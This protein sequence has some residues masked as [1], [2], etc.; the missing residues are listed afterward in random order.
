MVSVIRRTARCWL[1]AATLSAPG[2]LAEG[3]PQPAYPTQDS[4]TLPI[5]GDA[6]QAVNPYRTAED[7]GHV[8]G[9][10][11]TG[12]RLFNELCAACHGR[13]AEG[14]RAPAPDL[15]GLHAF[16]RRVADPALR[17]RCNADVDAYFVHSVL[18]GKTKLGIVYMP[19]WSG[20][21][22]QEQLWAI[23]SFIETRR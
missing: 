2:A 17:E 15:R 11:G 3:I 18:E 9:I 6:W 23:K 10:A 12:G 16:C 8:D 5:L 19:A 22:S 21:L 7:K 13:D 14:D 4:S 1:W 20:F